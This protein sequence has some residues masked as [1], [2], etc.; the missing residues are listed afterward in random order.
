MEFP[1]MLSKRPCHAFSA[2][3]IKL[4]M[5]SVLELLIDGKDIRNGGTEIVCTI[6]CHGIAAKRCLS[7]ENHFF[8]SVIMASKLCR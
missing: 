7:A 3:S 4:E 2:Q 8:W 5:A 6:G 1:R